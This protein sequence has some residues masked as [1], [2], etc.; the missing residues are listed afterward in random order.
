ML[1]NDLL[2]NF[3][4]DIEFSGWTDTLNTSVEKLHVNG[5]LVIAEHKVKGV[6][7]QLVKDYGMHILFLQGNKITQKHSVIDLIKH[8]NFET[9]VSDFAKISFG[10]GRE[11]YRSLMVNAIKHFKV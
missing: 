8:Q 1:N 2:L 11:I 5:K 4:S 7:I 3:K 10:Q 9:A 6:K